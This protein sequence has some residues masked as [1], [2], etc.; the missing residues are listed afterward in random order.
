M[1]AD[2]VPP[3]SASP[4][5]DAHSAPFASEWVTLSRLEHIE[6]V[7]R[8][9]RYRSLHERAVIRAAWREERYQKVLRQLKAQGAQ[10]EAA[11]QAQLEHAQARIRDLQKR[12]FG[13]KTERHPGNERRGVRGDEAGHVQRPRGHQRGTPGHGRTLQP[14]LPARHE[15]IELEHPQCARCGRPFRVFPGT[16]DA[17]II[18]IEVKAYRRVVHRKRYAPVCRCG[19]TAGIVSAPPPARLI[20]RGKFGIS[21]WT[22]V[23][24]DKFA[25]GR[26]GHRLVC[27]LG[28]RGV[29]MSPGTLAGGL[30]AIAPLLEPLGQ[31]LR[32]RLRS[33]R[34]WHADETRW[35]VF[36][37]IEG[38]VGHKWY[39]WVFHARSVV[40]Y[41][42]DP[43]RSSQVVTDELG[44]VK[45]KETVPEGKDVGGVQKAI[46]SCDRY[47]AYKKFARLHPGV[48]LAYCWAHQRRDFLELAASHPACKAWALEWL[49]AI[50]QL[51]HLNAVR[52][53]TLADGDGDGDARDAAQTALREAMQSLED[54]RERELS[55]PQ[56]ATPARNV[57]LSMAVHWSGLSVFVDAAWVPMDN[58]AAERDMRGPVV[59]RKSFYGSGAR[60]SGQLA[61]T[62]YG[63]LATLGL[64]QINARTWLGA[65]LQACADN[66]NQTSIDLSPFLP[67]AMD[68]ARLAAM[69]AVPAAASAE[70]F[71]TS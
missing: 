35:A 54:R 56:L 44:D 67:W 13:D 10:R 28:D 48:V 70:V 24:L 29:H 26:P 21:V 64:W 5:S 17:E 39:L 18:E 51:Y 50:G 27:D 62:M 4:A 36:V 53:Q 52:V 31:A 71:D 19:C 66:G 3:E 60:W 55:D 59:G 14:D 34:H 1:H 49:E 25:Y 43:T 8:A 6:L 45:Y 41:V 63:V 16:D 68:E 40:H 37:D 11:L 22:H 32:A 2:A 61:A 42:L 12:L 7:S 15:L 57:L 9:H 46:L 33:E 38:R 47:S 58:N 69:R 20:E 65:Y 23:L 30:Q